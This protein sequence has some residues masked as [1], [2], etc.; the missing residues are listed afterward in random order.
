[1]AYYF[2]QTHVLTVGS[3]FDEIKRINDDSK[4]VILGHSMGA[5]I[6]ITTCATFPD[7]MFGLILIDG[8][9]Q[10]SE[11]ESNVCNHLRTAFDLDKNKLKK[12]S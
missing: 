4:V 11:P 12:E 3:I 1:M 10:V 2:H 9:G 7:M 8:V 6:A 5:G